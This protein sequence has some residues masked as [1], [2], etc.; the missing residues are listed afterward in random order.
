MVDIRPF[1]GYRYN[2]SVVGELS[3]LLCPPYDVISPAQ[4]RELYQK[5]PFNSVRL[6]LTEQLPN[7]TLQHNRYTRAADTFKGWLAKGVLVPDVPSAMYL[8]EEEFNFRGRV[9]VRTGLTACVKLE[10]FEK[11]VIVPHEYT[12]SAPKKDRLELMKACHANISPIMALYSDSGGALTHLLSAARTKPSL[13]AGASSDGVIYRVWVIQ[14]QDILRGI[15]E[16]L[17]D[18]PVYLADGHHR[19]ETALN[20]RNLQRASGAIKS[21]AS[22]ANFVMMTLIS[23]NDPGLLI[24]PYHRLVGGL[25]SHEEKALSAL[26]NERF[27]WEELQLTALSAEGI[28]AT[29]E[30]GLQGRAQGD[31]VFGCFMLVSGK[32]KGYLL[33][34]KN[35]HVPGPEAPPLERC[36]T[37]LLHQRVLNPVLGEHE[38]GTKLAFVHDAVEAVRAVQKGEQQMAILLRPLPLKLFEEVVGQGNRLPPKATFFYPKLPTGLVFN[39]LE[40][41]MSS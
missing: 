15:H 35:A 23:M 27:E 7:D 24:F 3:R 22:T 29:L 20:Y 34:L 9:R 25:N 19:Y 8:I 12:T 16:A 21:D 33:T 37:W 4:Q 41:E 18:R 1:S 30:E 40:G 32:G 17:S 26:M 31:V 39:R 6:E 14:N 36:D 38:A 28:A 2:P 5:S 13:A 11:G 10:E